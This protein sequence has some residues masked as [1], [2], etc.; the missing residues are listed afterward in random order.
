M[1]RFLAVFFF[2]VVISSAQETPPE[3]KEEPKPKWDVSNPPGPRAKIDL[4]TDSGTWMN[5]DVSPKGDEIVF[6]LLGDIYTIPITGGTAKN[7]TSGIAWDMQPRYS[8]DGSRIAFTSDRAGGDN[9]WIMNRDG[10][11]PVQVTKEDYRLL[12][13]PVWTPDG[14]YIAAR[15]HLTAQ[16]SLGA[17]EIWLYHV[18]GGAGLQLTKKANDQKDAGEP[19]FSRDGRYML[20]SLDAT[21]GSNFEYNKD[22]NTQIYAINRL[23]RETG[24]VDRVVGGPGGAVRPTPSPDGKS[25]AFVRRVRTRSVLFVR[26]LASGIERPIY[27]QLDRDM[28]ETWAIHGVIQTSLGCQIASRWF[29]GRAERF[30]ESRVDTREASEIPFRVQDTREVT[31]ALRFPVD[32]APDKFNV[33]MLRWV[34]VSPKGDSVVY[35]ALGHIYIRPFPDGVPR[36]LTKQTTHFEQHPS[37]SPDGR[38]VIYTTWNDETL[39]SIRVVTVDGGTERSITTQPG[40]YA[41][42]K[43]SPDGKQ[44]VFTRGAGSFI[45]SQTWSQDP[46]IYVMPAEG[47]EASGLRSPDRGRTS[48]R[49]AIAFSSPLAQPTKRNCAASALTGAILLRT[50]IVDD[51]AEIVVSPDS[52]WVAFTE[53]FKVYIAPFPLTG[54]PVTLG[55]K[56][57]ALPL[58]RLNRDAGNYLHWSGDSKRLHWALGPELFTRSLQESFAFM[59]GAPEKLPEP[60]DSGVNIAFEQPADIPS[61]SLALVGARI[62]TMRGDEILQKGAVVIERNRIAAVGE[63]GKVK[64][65]AGAKV[66]DV[67][68]KT[69]I[70]G[71]VDVHAHG[72]QGEAGIIPQR[73]W[74]HYATLA[75][76]V[77]TTH[78][79]SNETNTVFAAGE[80][81]RAGLLVAPRIFST[82]TILYGATSLVRAETNS[83]DDAKSHVRRLKAVGAFSVKSY[84]QPRRDQRQQIIAAARELQMM[85]V[86]EGGSLYHHNMNMIVD[87]HTGIEHSVP[88][89]RLYEDV[90]QFWPKTKVGYT[91]TIGVAYGGIFGENYWYQHTNVWENERL[92]RYVPSAL[93][94]RARAV[95]RW[96]RKTSSI[97]STSLAGRSNFSIGE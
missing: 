97:T 5:L 28:Q 22:P 94:T 30:A 55:G 35:Q 12:N 65:P 39:G 45:L 92:L 61:G 44:I 20:F 24:D 79:P 62:I 16:R 37:F 40:H 84:N 85:V 7:L 81:M 8:P 42:P 57:T 1:P 87:G 83:L 74:A 68:G 15:K 25:L 4:N 72:P 18:S 52:Q 3:K 75:F 50:L 95:A 10:S 73:N 26:D 9:I 17:G 58:R 27:D 67:T 34:N 51:A 48:A 88:V 82:G 31:E 80:M 90:L 69:I 64:I 19:A 86:P 60:M 13:N 21:P 78:D 59:E 66:I 2:A 77:T 11:K 29:S 38:S 36:R 41:D 63:Q 76:G 33:K 93:S 43:Y 71:L 23:D 53:L 70:P 54:Q 46:G 47:G 14:Q 6:D 89:G 96:P 56:S 49:A 91:P 32:V